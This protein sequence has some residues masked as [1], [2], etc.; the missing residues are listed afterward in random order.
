MATSVSGESRNPANARAEPPNIANAHNVI[1][2]EKFDPATQTWKRWLQRLEGFFKVFKITSGEEKVVYLLHYIGVEAFGVL[3]DRLDPDDPYAKSFEELCNKLGEY[4]APEPLEIAEIYTFRKRMQ[5]EGEAAQEYLAALQKLSLYCKFGNYLNTELR[6]QFVFGIKNPRIQA[7]L[8]E[9]IDL[10]KE[11]A[12]K[13]ACAME[14]ADQGVNKLKDESAVCGKNHLAP[15]CSLPRSTKCLECGGYGHLKKVCKKKGQTDCV[16][17]ATIDL[18]HE[19]VSHRSKYTVSLQIEDR[20]IEFDVDSGAA[21]TLNFVPMGFVKVKVKDVDTWKYLNMYIVEYNRQPLL[22]REWINQLKSFNKFKESLEEVQSLHLVELSCNKRLKNLLEKYAN[23][24]SDDFEPIKKIKAQLNLK[25]NSQPVFLR[26]RQVPFQIKNKVENELNR[27]VKAGILKPV[28]ASTWATPIVPVL[29]KDGGVRICGDFS[30]TVNSCLIVDEHPLPTH[31]ELFAKMAGCNVFSKIDLKQAYLQLEL[32]NEDKEILTLNTSK[33]LYQCNRLMYGVASAS[34]IWQRTIENILKNIPDITVFLDD[35]KIASVNVEKHFEILELVLN[36]LSE[37]NIR[38]NLEKCAFLKSQISYCGHIIGMDGIKKEKKKM[39]AVEKLPRPKNVSEVRAFIGLI[40]YYGRFIENMSDILKPLN[41]LLKKNSHFKWTSACERAFNSAKQ[42]FCNDKILVSFNPNLPIVLATDASPYGVGA[43]LSHV[44]PNGTERVIEYASNT[45][46][47][48]QRKYTQIDKEAYAI[49]FG[50]KKFHN[51]LYGKHFTLLTDNKPLTQILNPGKGLPAY[52][53]MRMQHYAVFLQG[54]DFDIKFRKTENHGNADGFSRLPIKENNRAR[55][56]A[57]DVYTV[58]TLNM[59]PVKASEIQTET[60]NDENLLK[61]V[62]AL[63][64]GKCLKKFG[65][66]NHEFA[67]NNGI[68]LRKDRVVIPEKFRN[69][70]LKE[71]HL[72]HIGIVRMKALARNYVWWQGIDLEIE[73][74]VRSCKECSRVQNNPK[75]A[76]LHH[77]EPTEEAFERIHMDFA[78]PFA[79]YN[80]LVCVDAHTKWPEVYV[81]N[82]ITASSTIGKCREIFARFGIPRMLVTDNGR[83]FISQDFQNFIK[84][85]GIIHRLTAP[86]HPATNGAAERFVQTLK[87]WLRKTNLEKENV[88]CSVQK[89]LFHYRITPFPELKQSPAEIMFGRKL[90]NRLDLLS[91]KEM[92]IKNK[93]VES[94]ETRNFQ[95]GNKI[96]AREYLNKKAKWRFGIVYRKLGKLHYLIRLENGKIW[97]RHVNQ[98]RLNEQNS[99][100]NK[101]QETMDRFNYSNSDLEKSEI[102]SGGERPGTETNDEAISSTV[103]IS[104]EEGTGEDT[105]EQ[106]ALP[107]E[108]TDKRAGEL[109]S[110]EL[111]WYNRGDEVEIK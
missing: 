28:E 70:I 11:R 55:Y 78:G 2:I 64:Q 1:Q 29:K 80:F 89:F 96:A 109:I 10:T 7:R 69:K 39:E 99:D 14:M 25:P 62:E 91:P 59:L 97:K 74:T 63:E 65:L 71:L 31:E 110:L 47:D 49:I 37:Y 51:F 82:N 54:F 93:P 43:V 8:L 73:K 111:R 13:I 30:V 58:D 68:L 27:M 108:E 100:N 46:N 22:G 75:P 81:M 5:K 18:E 16:D 92:E 42:A 6:N 50:I 94:N 101:S 35:I 102:K 44:Y 72:G 107:I 66:Q 32:R 20:K 38:I 3:C 40:N 79:G 95:V 17:I 56:D 105:C 23:L 36:R 83:T 103:H 48:T 34:A 77:W 67:L 41:D 88:K 26:S 90:R 52:S 53:A 87:Q 98:L 4:Y 86:Y 12:L 60:R 57:L 61:I 9:T 45:L 84:A 19:H 76:P 106:I 104:P 33:G 15:S 24:I 21:V 85:N